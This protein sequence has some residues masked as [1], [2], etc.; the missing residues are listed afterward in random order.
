MFPLP[1]LR[2]CFPDFGSVLRLCL[3]NQTS[4]VT[5]R[6]NFDFPFPQKL[7]AMLRQLPGSRRKG[8]CPQLTYAKGPKSEDASESR[9]WP[10]YILAANPA[11]QVTVVSFTPQMHGYSTIDSLAHCSRSIERIGA[12]NMLNYVYISPHCPQ[13]FETIRDKHYSPSSRNALPASLRRWCRD[14]CTKRSPT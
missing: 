9:S 3:R 8:G 14:T 6:I 11:M 10:R 1:R 2:D 4:F 13:C 7:H 12:I 5:I